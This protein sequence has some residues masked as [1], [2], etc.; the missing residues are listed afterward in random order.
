MEWLWAALLQYQSV[1]AVPHYDMALKPIGMIVA[2]AV[3]GIEEAAQITL[4]VPPFASTAHT[5]VEC[6]SIYDYGC[7]C[8][9]GLQK[10][11]YPIYGTD[12]RDLHQ[13]MPPDYSPQRSDIVLFK[14]RDKK[15]GEP[16]FHAASVQWIF[17]S[18]NMQIYECNFKPGVCGERV[19]FKNDRAIR[20]Y[21]HNAAF[22]KIF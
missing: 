2:P 8:M 10:L 12:A 16:V 15:T 14:Y 7:S 13:N 9:I 11:G 6:E 19:I 17:P 22:E 1:K 3:V 21:I 18:G 4:V 20:G 5:I